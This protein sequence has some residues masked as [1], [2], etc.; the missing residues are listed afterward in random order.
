MFQSLTDA[1]I[2]ALEKKKAA[3]VKAAAKAKAAREQATEK[4][5]AEAR[6]RESKNAGGLMNWMGKG[7]K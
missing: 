2:S 7:G 5:V 4:R 1:E 3:S 6:L